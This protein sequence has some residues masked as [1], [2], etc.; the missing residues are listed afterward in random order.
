MYSIVTCGVF[1]YPVFGVNMQKN[2]ADG[3]GHGHKDDGDGEGDAVPVGL[4]L[5]HLRRCHHSLRI[6][7]IDFLYN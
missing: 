6:V 4:G 3:C 5:L 1:Q 2:I 7:F